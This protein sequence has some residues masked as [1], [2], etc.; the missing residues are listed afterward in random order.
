M[1]RATTA[2]EV[3]HKTVSFLERVMD[4]FPDEDVTPEDLIADYLERL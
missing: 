1:R 3:H 4:D 2:T